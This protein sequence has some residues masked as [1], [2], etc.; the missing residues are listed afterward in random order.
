MTKPN[1]NRNIFRQI[2]AAVE[3]HQRFKKVRVHQSFV[4]SDNWPIVLILSLTWYTQR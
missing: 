4:T 2:R 1:E 3:D